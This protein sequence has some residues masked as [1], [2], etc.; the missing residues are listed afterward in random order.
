MRV[1]LILVAIYYYT[2]RESRKRTVNEN[3]VPDR[4]EPLLLIKRQ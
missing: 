1:V 3:G 2:T 4:E